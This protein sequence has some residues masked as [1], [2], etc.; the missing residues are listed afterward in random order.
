[1]Y[2]K[3]KHMDEAREQLINTSK[4][5]DR[6]VQ[7]RD[8]LDVALKAG[9]ITEQQHNLL[10]V[11]L[12]GEELATKSN[13]LGETMTHIEALIQP[14]MKTAEWGQDYVKQEMDA[15][16]EGVIVGSGLHGLMIKPEDSVVR[17]KYG[18]AHLT[19]L[20]PEQLKRVASLKSALLNFVTARGHTIFVD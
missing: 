8:A 12:S 2:N 6:F 4:K 17:D 14:V 9:E 19:G 3:E 5:K 10:W 20:K 15:V 1:M 18:V 11:K 16:A 13:S 7:S